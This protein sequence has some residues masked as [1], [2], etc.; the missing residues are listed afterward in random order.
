[1]QGC[2]QTPTQSVLEHGLSVWEWTDDLLQ[3]LKTGTS[4]QKDWIL[5]DWVDTYRDL[6]C[7]RL[8]P[9]DV[10]QQYTIFHDCGKPL[11]RVVDEDGK[12]HFPDHANVSADLWY[13]ISGDPVVSDLIRYDMDIHTLSSEDVSSFSIRPSAV[14]NLLVGLAEIHS[15]AQMF[16]GVSST[17]F[18]I[19]YKKIS[20]RGKQIL[21]RLSET[22]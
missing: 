15:N 9:E 13:S 14:T 10:I 19:K 21:C 12:Q 7:Q 18:K 6:I 3:Y 4:L 8:Y 2:P 5:P 1:M 17:S 20:Q 16:G 11:C 22:P